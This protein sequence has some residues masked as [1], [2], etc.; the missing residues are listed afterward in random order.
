[1]KINKEIRIK[2]I[3]EII[4]RYEKL[5]SEVNPYGYDADEGMKYYH[6]IDYWERRL[7]ELKKAFPK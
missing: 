3:K 7:S 2:A 4:A 1:M 6:L 5:Q